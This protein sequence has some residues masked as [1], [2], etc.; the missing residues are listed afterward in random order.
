MG[1]SA[2]TSKPKAATCSDDRSAIPDKGT[3]QVSEGQQ[4]TTHGPQD[5]IGPL[6]REAEC[7]KEQQ[8][9][10]RDNKLRL[11]R[12]M[13]QR[14]QTYAA[15]G[16]PKPGAK[17]NKTGWRKRLTSPADAPW[18]S[19][20]QGADALPKH[21]TRKS[22]YSR[23]EAISTAVRKAAR[24]CSSGVATSEAVEVM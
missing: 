16:H 20:Q 15:Q 11:Y 10:V 8:N 3:S 22:T 13:P 7:R 5:R 24:S 2:G 6:G 21:K 18:E 4:G 17:S 1:M 19:T 14:G 23:D 12:E 9:G